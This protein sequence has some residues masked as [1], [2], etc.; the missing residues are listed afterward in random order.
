[1]PF[2]RLQKNSCR[3]PSKLHG[4]HAKSLL[5]IA[6]PS[7]LAHRFPSSCDLPICLY[8]DKDFNSLSSASTTSLLPI[9]ESPS[10][11]ISYQVGELLEDVALL[12]D[13]QNG[14]S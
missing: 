1:M 5:C 13:G 14:S 2:D 12:A 10:Q 4:Y 6:G 8:D 7:S 11:G 9:E 3:D